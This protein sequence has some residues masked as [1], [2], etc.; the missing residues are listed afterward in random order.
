MNILEG[1][2]VLTVIQIANRAEELIPACR[3]TESGKY[4]AALLMPPYG[5]IL[6]S[7]DAS[8]NSEDDGKSHM[9][10]LIAACCEHQ[11]QQ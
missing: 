10:D 4:E 9:R 6:V 7:T 3:A 2:S 11:R 5:R 1:L 8:F